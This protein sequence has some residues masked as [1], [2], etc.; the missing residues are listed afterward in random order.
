MTSRGTRGPSGVAV[1]TVALTSLLNPLN[2]SMLAV[3]LPQVQREF[4]TSAG[5]STWLHTLFAFV[6]AIGHP[7]AGVL[8]D[9]L[10]PRRV[11]IAG[12]R[13]PSLPEELDHEPRL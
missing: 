3:A 2:T 9:R 12:R 4:G 1:G 7:L 5:A 10:G 11:L 8:A 13:S 6:S